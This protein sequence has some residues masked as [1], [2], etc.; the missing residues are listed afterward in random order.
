MIWRSG[1]RL[2]ISRSSVRASSSALAK[3]PEEGGEHRLGVV[4]RHRA[5]RAPPGAFTGTR[6]HRSRAW[7]WH[8]HE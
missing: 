2:K 7:S 5:E 1:E 8:W 3:W 4:G 6:C